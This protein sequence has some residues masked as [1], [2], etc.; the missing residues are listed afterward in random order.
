MLAYPSRKR[1]HENWRGRQND[2]QDY[3]TRYYLWFH[4]LNVSRILVDTRAEKFNFGIFRSQESSLRERLLWHPQWYVLVLLLL[5]TY[6]VCIHVRYLYSRE[7]KSWNFSLS[8]S[9]TYLLFLPFSNCCCYFSSTLS[10]WLDDDEWEDIT[11]LL[12]DCLHKHD[13]DVHKGN[14]F[15]FLLSTTI[16]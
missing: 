1:A 11:D 16:L 10:F 7:K 15:F 9:Y 5:H 4:S 8:H 3:F 6:C 14:V 13:D 12:L 2:H